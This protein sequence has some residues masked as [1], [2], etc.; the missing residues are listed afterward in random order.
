[1]RSKPWTFALV[2]S[3]AVS[4]ACRVEA[5]P[6]TVPQADKAAVVQGNNA[7]ALDLY[8]AL[9]GNGGNLFVSPYSISTA[10]AMTYAG[11][12]GETEAQMAK[13]LH[14]NLPQDR[15]HPAMG[16]LVQ[17]LNA[18]GKGK[19]QLIVA[20]ALWGQKGYPFLQSFLGL[21]GKYYGA[22][23]EQ[24]DFVRDR[25]GSRKTINRWVEEQTQD[26]IKDLLKPPHITPL[27]TLVLTNAVYFKGNW[28]SQFD[29]EHTR[30]DLFTLK[31]GKKI[32]MPM[33]HKTDEFGYMQ[34]DGLQVLELPYVGGDLSM[35]VLLPIR[36][37]GL[38]DIEK[39][40][41]VQNIAEWTRKLRKRK[42]IV[43]LPRFKMTS[44][45]E[46]GRT[47][48]AMGMP[49]AF[50]GAADFSGMTGRRDLFISEVV[51]KAFVEVNEE[52]TE[53]AAATAVI[54]ERKAI[55]RPAIFRADHPFLFLIRDNRS[56]SIL[57]V[58]RL[59]KP[60]K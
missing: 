43:A 58:G 51:H 57:F 12:R 24:V 20:N 33:M 19:Y 39:S 10:L 53:A 44:E 15:L 40:L 26:K 30:D 35:L 22:G 21:N 14:L 38:A 47:L 6:A 5:R 59:E 1:M 11:A 16:A 34:A 49:K 25:N 32:E 27:T 31:S 13:V 17:E 29:K 3:V 54:M 42:V 2:L 55:S 48:K 37:D 36:V 52:G 45:F 41:T 4:A 7:F 46:L 23:L 18:R 56:K 28:A 8:A 9:R 60:V 50:S